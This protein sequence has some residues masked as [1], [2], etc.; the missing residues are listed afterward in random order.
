MLVQVEPEAGKKVEELL[1]YKVLHL[2]ISQKMLVQ[3]EPE[4]GKS[5]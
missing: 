1:L 2:V 3:V 4:A 5:V